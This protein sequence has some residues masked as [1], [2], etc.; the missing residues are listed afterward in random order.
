MADDPTPQLGAA[1][2]TPR[3]GLRAS[4]DDRDGV[5]EQL[6]VA[7][8]DGRLDAAELDERVGAALVAR[9]Y[10]E[11]AALVSDLPASRGAAVDRV[12]DV[13]RID[14]SRG[15]THRDGRWVVP[16]RIAVKIRS[17]SVKLDFTEALVS[18]PTVQIDAD[19]SHGNLTIITKPGI[20]V[21]TGEVAIHGGNV[22]VIAP[23]GAAAA[24]TLRIDVT[25]SVKGGNIKARPAAVSFWSWLRRAP[26]HDG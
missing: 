19:V 15:S 26:R 25:G 1:D 14:V 9:T 22:R 16:Q 17:G 8:G 18:W 7:G 11:L 13:A 10:G 20:V 6:R 21:E 24:S 5:V 4:H 23:R 12:K 2:S 3:D